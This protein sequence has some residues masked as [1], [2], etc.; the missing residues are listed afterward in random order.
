MGQIREHAEMDLDSPTLVEGMPG[1]GLVG[2][3]ATDH[4]IDEFEMTYYASVHCEGLAPIGVY[5]EGGR[6]VR[7][8]VRLYADEDLDLLALRS[9]VPVAVDTTSEFAAC[10]TG[11]LDANDV[12][13]L[14]LSGFPAEKS[15]APPELFGVATSD[16]A[17]DRL[18][19]HGID[20]P[21]VNGAIA[22]P[23]GALLNR[24]AQIEHDA[25]AL[26]VESDPRF[27]DPEA[28]R[29]LL[30]EGIEP[31]ADIEVSVEGLVEQADSIRKQREQLAQRMQE[32]ETQ[33][34]SQAQP[35]QMF[36]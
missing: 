21:T 6:E 36:Q 2:K 12:D 9:D 29:V 1:I 7:P 16:A 19:H 20:H 28:A 35:I 10:L 4:L 13:P 8:P 18:D 27:P 30:T 5:E 17:A 3:I 14:Y 33:E 26:V 15:D 11:W 32:A 24:A 23:A 31:L 25:T 34:S 22:G